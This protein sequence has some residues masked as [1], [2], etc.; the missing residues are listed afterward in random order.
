[1]NEQQVAEAVTDW[2][3]DIIPTLNEGYPYVSS[4]H[5][6]LP[7]VMVDVPLK[8]VTLGDDAFPFSALQQRMLRVFSV[9]V[10][11]MVE[12]ATGVE[13]D[14]DKLETEMLR[15]YGATIEDSGLKDATLG[16]RVFMLS[17]LMEFDYTLPFVEYPDGTRGRQMQ[18]NLSVG[19]LVDEEDSVV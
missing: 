16:E 17:P 8:S 2:I 19:E 10:N 15:G 7:D 11:I 14:A 1:M 9:T 3:R 5:G 13:P 18:V 12:T 4:N 6:E